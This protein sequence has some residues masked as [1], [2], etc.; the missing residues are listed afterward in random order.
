MLTRS[1]ND[2]AAAGRAGTDGI[3]LR[4][5]LVNR[6]LELERVEGPPISWLVEGRLL[7]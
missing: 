7:T 2:G 4:P 1:A 6:V 5:A 3:G